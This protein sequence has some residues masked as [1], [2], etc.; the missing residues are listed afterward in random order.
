M[1]ERIG[2]EQIGSERIGVGDL[3]ASFLEACGVDAAFGVISIHNMPILDAIGR[4]NRIRFVT[5][6]GEAGALN[7]ADAHARVSGG[8]GVAFTSTGT[9]AGNACGALVEAQTAGTALLHITGQI[10]RDYLDQDRGYIHEASDQLAMLRAVSKAA[11]RV[12][13]PETLLGTLREAV[14]VARSAPSGPVSVEI[15]IDIQD[16][17]VERPGEIA[18]APSLVP[19]PDSASLDALA[20]ALAGARRPMVW[21]G[22]GTRAAAAEARALVELG[23]GCVTSIQ[24]RGVIAE[25]HPRSLGAFNFQPAVEAFYRTCDAMV[26]VGSRLRGNET[27]KYRLALPRPLYRIDADARADGRSYTNDLFIA[28]DAAAALG[29][30]A[31]RLAGRMAVD[32]GFAADLAAARNA[33][34]KAMRETLG[35]YERLADAL[36]DAAPPDLVWVRDITLSNSTWGN[37]MPRLAGPRDGVHALGGGIGQGLP[38]AIGAAMA[39]GA[40][41]TVAMIGDGGFAVTLGEISTLVQERAPV[42]L[43]VMNDG[44]Y[45]VI[46][47]IQDHK[48]EG[49]RYFAN[50]TLPDLAKLCEALGLPFRRVE[51][52]DAIRPALD[53]AIAAD[54]PTLIEIDMNALGPFTRPFAGPPVRQDEVKG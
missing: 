27:L 32:P 53:W 2:S 40:R 45:G 18:P 36:Q 23:F 26:V 21:L 42:A 54:G 3:V 9:A 28:G 43:I 50:V 7:M 38:M 10:E 5:A 13:T 48:F 15:P 29:G 12:L 30:L 16:A 46:R 44:G 49:R 25:G 33:A 8:L 35:P 22:G 20:D 19:L 34:E 51:E 31:E 37:R 41:K 11:Y 47:N 6:R 17:L 1:S 39:A 52:E 14:R 4:R 24:G